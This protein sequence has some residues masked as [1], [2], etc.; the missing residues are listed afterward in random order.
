M[1]SRL[2]DP[3]PRS[4][5]PSVS[6]VRRAGPILRAVG[7]TDTFADIQNW[8]LEEAATEREMLHLLVKLITRMKA[9]GSL[10]DRLTL[11]IGTL[12]PQLVGFAWVW[13]SDD[14]FCDEVRVADATVASDAYKL[15]PL[16]R[17]V[18]TGETIRR[19][20]N[21]LSA[22]AEFPIMA[23]LAAA[24]MTDYAAIPLCGLDSRNVITIAT[25]SP[26]GFREAEFDCLMDL[27]KLF[28]LHVQRHSELRISENALGA[29][30]GSGAAAKV[31]EGAIKR[32]AGDSIRAV[33]WVSDLRNFTKMSDALAPADMLV[34]LNAYFEAMAS[35]VSAHGGETLK[36]IGDG[37]LAVFPVTEG[38]AE[39]ARAAASAAREAIA[40]L[41]AYSRKIRVASAAKGQPLL[42]AGIVLHEG[43]VFFGNIGAPD[44]LD[45]TVIGAAVNEACRVEALTKTIGRDLLMTEAVARHLPHDVEHLGE[46]QLRGVSARMA[47]YG[48]PDDTSKRRARLCP[49]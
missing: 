29:Y 31:L 46:H 14:G 15:N 28:A 5:P 23:E 36:F 42:R 12:H 38:V 33:I 2:V 11:H 24:G 16:Q 21:D 3:S 44:R 1:A 26:G 22:Q 32:G 48:L 18:E 8:L 39:A 49:P 17:I 34:L 43:E 20:P 9:A 25:K 41:E 10:V 4:Y 37:M 35:A 6:F 19:E 7:E 40:R 13:N 47:V 30:L 45:F 27:F